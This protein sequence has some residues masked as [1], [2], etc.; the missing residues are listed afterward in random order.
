M[1]ER[2]L[3]L[4]SSYQ[5]VGVIT[6]KDAIS[7]LYQGKAETL[8]ELD[9]ETNE[10]KYTIHNREVSN[11]VNE[12][13]KIKKIIVNDGSKTITEFENGKIKYVYKIPAIVRLIDNDVF[14][15]HKKI[16]F[17]KI[18]NFYRDN[19]TCAYCGY[20]QEPNTFIH[21]KRKKLTIDH[22]IP[23]SKG[24]VT[25]FSNCITACHE[26]NSK[27]ADKTPQEAGMKLLWKPFIP[28]IMNLMKK[29]LNRK[30]IHNSWEQYLNSYPN[31][32]VAL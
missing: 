31:A 9:K 21:Q 32:S 30:Q 6:W 14:P 1:K 7:L 20:K 16:K 26:C 4:N 8:K 29:K 13:E 18:N 15:T 28:S 17:S 3:V 27:K 2:T 22:V 11:S 10:Y 5:V 25:S 23:Q 19:H 24:G 12:K